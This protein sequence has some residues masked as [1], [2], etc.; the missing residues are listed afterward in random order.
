V[1]EG[2]GDHTLDM[3]R[4]VQLVMRIWLARELTSKNWSSA[5][6]KMVHLYPNGDDFRHWNTCQEYL[7]H[8]YAVLSHYASHGTVQ[9]ADSTFL[10]SKMGYFLRFVGQFNDELIVNLR[11]LK[12]VRQ[13]LGRRVFPPR[14][15]S[16]L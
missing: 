14:E 15:S 5:A 4:L 11:A 6:L 9:S 10:L 8:A 12:I 3:H 16:T 13:L 2:K 7:P 1:S